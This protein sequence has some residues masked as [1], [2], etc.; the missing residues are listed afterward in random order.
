MIEDMILRTIWTLHKEVG[1]E[2]TATSLVA[3]L[4]IS[5]ASEEETHSFVVL[6]RMF[7]L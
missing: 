4:T 6:T 7:L 5:L 3:T 1:K 2:Y